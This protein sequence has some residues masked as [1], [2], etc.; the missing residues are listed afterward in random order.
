MQNTPGTQMTFIFEGQFPDFQ[1]VFCFESKQGAPW[2]GNPGM[3]SI[4]SNL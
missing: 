4:L 3:D 1:G 2:K